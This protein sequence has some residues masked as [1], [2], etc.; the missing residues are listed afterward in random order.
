[1]KEVNNAGIDV[2]K[3]DNA[4]RLYVFSI[5]N[6]HVQPA[7]RLCAKDPDILYYIKHLSALFPNAKFVAMVRD[8]RATI[9]SLMNRIGEPI[10][11]TSSVSEFVET[12]NDYYEQVHTD[13]EFIGTH[14]CTF[15]RYEDL[16]LQPNRTISE[17][18]N[19]LGLTWTDDFLRHDEF[20]GGKVRVSETEWSSSQVK[21]PIY[22]DSLTSWVGK[23]NFDLSMLQKNAP[24][25][26]K[27][28]KL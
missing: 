14:R 4:L 18:A 10:N 20:V 26:R 27:F 15:V 25:L 22:T 24:I 13:C 5:L 1:M 11:S 28:Y 19:M 9:Y 17:V 16:I 21:K 2:I 6:E 23:M 12:W 8:P 3:L 7:E